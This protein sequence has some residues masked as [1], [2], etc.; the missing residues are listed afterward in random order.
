MC[1][2]TD[3]GFYHTTSHRHPASTATPQVSS[4]QTFT[5]G[6]WREPPHRLQS[7]GEGCVWGGGGRVLCALQQPYWFLQLLRP[8]N[9]RWLTPAGLSANTS[10]LPSP[11][12]QL[13][14]LPHYLPHT[15]TT[16]V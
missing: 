9:N 4:I 7:E 6:K 8:Y 1:V 14:I 15:A 12:R 2:Y 10:S 11:F 16:R 3:N 5:M 13:T